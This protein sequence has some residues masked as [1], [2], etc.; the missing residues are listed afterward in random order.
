MKW[1][2]PAVCL[3]LLLAT[4]AGAGKPDEIKCTSIYLKT[5]NKVLKLYTKSIDKACKKELAPGAELDELGARLREKL[6]KIVVSYNK[7][8]ADLS[9]DAEL[10]DVG[11]L[12]NFSGMELA[13]LNEPNVMDDYGYGSTT[14]VLGTALTACDDHT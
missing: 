7:K 13:E 12:L 3:G 11:N 10:D 4:P 2:L 6:N 8:T 5:L 9:C 14:G 1:V